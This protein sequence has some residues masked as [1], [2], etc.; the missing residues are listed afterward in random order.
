V[1]GPSLRIVEPRKTSVPCSSALLRSTELKHFKRPRTR[2]RS[3]KRKIDCKELEI[4]PYGRLRKKR[5]FFRGVKTERQGL[6]RGNLKRLYK[7]LKDRNEEKPRRFRGGLKQRL[8]CQVIDLEKT[9]NSEG[10]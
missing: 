2:R 9:K 10:M 4:E 5:T 7:R 8:G 3:W 6:Q 1:V